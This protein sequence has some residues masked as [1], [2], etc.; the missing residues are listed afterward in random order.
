[1]FRYFEQLIDGLVYELFF[2][3]QF[4][5]AGKSLFDLVESE[6]LPPFESLST[7]KLEKLRTV[8]ERLHLHTHPIR[9]TLFFL[10]TLEPVRI[11][12]GKN[13]IGFLVLGIMHCAFQPWAKAS[14]PME[15]YTMIGGN[16]GQM[17]RWVYGWHSNR[18]QR[19]FT[20][21]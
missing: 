5:A 7:N 11:I 3:E 12:E 16:P 1:M 13:L 14:F 2:S 18:Q 20:R 21:N 17:F 8:F 19:P 9:Q 10:D 4:E 15:C 6:T